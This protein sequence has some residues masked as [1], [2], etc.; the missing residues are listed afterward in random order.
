MI[1]IIIRMIIS[2]MY[3]THWIDK[4][5]VTNGLVFERLASTK[6]TIVPTLSVGFPSTFS[7]EFGIATPEAKAKLKLEIERSTATRSS[8]ISFFNILYI[9]F[10]VVIT[11]LSTK[12]HIDYDF[13]CRKWRQFLLMLL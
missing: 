9:S 4:I 3:C 6:V 12:K 11:L 5:F 13:I 2:F 1:I 7:S 8:E 10:F